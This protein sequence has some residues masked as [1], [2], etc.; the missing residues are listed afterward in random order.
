[1]VASLHKRGCLQD[2]GIGNGWHLSQPRAL[3]RSATVGTDSC[4][5][6]PSDKM[7]YKYLTA[8]PEFP[9]AELND[10]LCAHKLFSVFRRRKSCLWSV[11][12]SLQAFGIHWLGVQLGSK[13]RLSSTWLMPGQDHYPGACEPT[14]APT[15]LSCLAQA[16]SG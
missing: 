10:P 12:P 5:L 8:P 3:A 9:I 11:E 7:C 15:W 6:H 16:R 14:R 4:G 2:Y 1:M 13:K